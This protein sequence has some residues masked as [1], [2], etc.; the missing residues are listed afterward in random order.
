MCAPHKAVVSHAEE[1]VEE[2]RGAYGSE[3]LRLR[4]KGDL[5]LE[6]GDSAGHLPELS[7]EHPEKKSVKNQ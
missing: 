2:R 7:T 4:A 1:V 3:E 5:F 6:A